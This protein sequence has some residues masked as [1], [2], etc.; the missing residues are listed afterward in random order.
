MSV[1]TNVHV[2]Q[3]PWRGYDDPGLPVGMYIAQGIVTGNGTGGAMTNIFGFKDEGDAASGRYYNIE[4]VEVQQSNT[5]TRD[6]AMKAVNWDSVASAGLLNREWSYQLQSNSGGVA[7]MVTRSQLPLPIFLGLAAP[8][9][10]LAAQ[11]E[12][13]CDNV[14]LTTLVAVIQG[15]I[16]EARSVLAEGGLRR[17]IDSL[18]GGGRQ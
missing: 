5:S 9:R 4:E 10:D 15:Y 8:V 1:V 16:W 14:D 11:I 17:P 13:S 3:R 12:I 18:Y 2:E 6:A 7:A